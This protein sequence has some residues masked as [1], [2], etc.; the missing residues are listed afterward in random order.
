MSRPMINPKPF[1]GCK[2]DLYMAGP[3]HFCLSFLGRSH[4]Q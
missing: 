1:Q 3:L 2:D 4:D